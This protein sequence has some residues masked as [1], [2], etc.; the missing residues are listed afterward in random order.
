VVVAVV[1]AGVNLV[2][3]N[4]T[5]VLP[6]QLEPHKELLAKA[7][8]EVMEPEVVAVVADKMAVLAVDWSPATTAAFQVKMATVWHPEVVWF[9][10]VQP[11]AVAPPTT[12]D[13][14]AQSQ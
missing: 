12:Q 4:L 1:G 6:E 14:R 5:K 7:E 8:A 11:A 13:P 2:L 9:L 3:G 10:V